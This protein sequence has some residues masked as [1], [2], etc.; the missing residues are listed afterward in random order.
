M[1]TPSWS[2]DSPPWITIRACGFRERWGDW[3]DLV[4]AFYISDG[5]ADPAVYDRLRTNVFEESTQDGQQYIW[6]P[7]HHVHEESGYLA[8]CPPLLREAVVLAGLGHAAPD[9]GPDGVCA[10]Q[11]DWHHRMGW[12]SDLLCPGCTHGGGHCSHGAGAEADL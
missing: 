1:F 5:P 8:I 3:N 2:G 6:L 9:G 10:W 11:G 12:Y 7:N 4:L